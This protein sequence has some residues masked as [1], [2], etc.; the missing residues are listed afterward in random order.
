MVQS[1]HA[2]R[3]AR[4]QY[5][6]VRRH[7]GDLDDRALHATEEGERYDSGGRTGGIDLFR[8]PR[9]SSGRRA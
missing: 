7:S 9:R 8:G 1:K 2:R 6:V 5:L 3:S 4:R